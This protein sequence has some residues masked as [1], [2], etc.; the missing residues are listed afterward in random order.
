MN[1][2]N[3]PKTEI[4]QLASQIKNIATE[5]GFDD[6]RIANCDLS[7]SAPRLKEWI[8]NGYAGDMDFIAKRLDMKIDPNKLVILAAIQPLSGQITFLM[9]TSLFTN[10]RYSFGKGWSKISTIMR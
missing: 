2:L 8:D 10:N 3:K 6:I 7:E 4:A 1:S 9:A 5:F